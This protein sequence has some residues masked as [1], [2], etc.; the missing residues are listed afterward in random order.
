MKINLDKT[1]MSKPLFLSLL[2]FLINLSISEYTTIDGSKLIS[3]SYEPNEDYDATEIISPK[4]ITQEML[5]Y[6]SWFTSYGYCQD[7]QIPDSCCKSRMAFFTQKWIIVDESSISDYYTYNYVIWRND[8]YKKYIL[9]F[10]GTRN[11]ILELLSEATHM[12]LVNFYDT[13]NGIKVVNYFYKVEQAIF[14]L[15]FSESTLQDISNH[16]GYQFIFTGHS[17]GGSVAALML[18]NAMVNNYLTEKNSPALITFGMPRT[19]N[20]DWVIDFNSRIKNIFRVERDGD[21]VPS[22][23]YSIINNKYRHL[24]GLILMNKDMNSLNVCPKDIGEDYP[25]SE[26]TLTKSVDLKYHLHYFN[27]DTELGLRCGNANIMYQDE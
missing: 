24:S 25:D 16:P 3:L 13:D 8:E 9:A 15:V 27:P 12:K 23:P 21:I 14:N 1:K 17:M 26:C 6:Y 10:P 5:S 7:E 2:F 4:T 22:L 11:N 20:E 18:Y 19:G